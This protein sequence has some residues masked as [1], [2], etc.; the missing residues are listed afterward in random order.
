MRGFVYVIEM[1]GLTKIGRT[2]RNPAHRVRGMQLPGKPT[3]F[4]YVV[5]DCIAAERKA[6]EMF[7]EQRTYGEWFALS[8]DQKWELN[9]VLAEEALNTIHLH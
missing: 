9:C 7:S 8:E 1:H 2:I 3:G 5:R 4:W 6:H